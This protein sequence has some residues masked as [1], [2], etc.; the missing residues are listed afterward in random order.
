ME[1]SMHPILAPLLKGREEHYPHKLE[2]HYARIFN[3]IMALWGKDGMDQYFADLFLTDRPERVGFPFEVMREINF[4]HDLHEESKKTG[5]ANEGVWSNE[6]IK[7]GLEAEGIEYS[8]RGFFRAIE[9]GNEKAIRLFLQ[10]GVD[11]NLPN[12]AGWTPL[13]VAIFL[14]NESAANQLLDAGA[15]SRCAG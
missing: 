1:N 13:M 2:T 7:R 6:V 4:L 12:D 3:E 8:Q 9:L 11:V 15:Q 10:A 14:S 5:P